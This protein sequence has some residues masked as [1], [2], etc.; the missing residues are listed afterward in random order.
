MG[1]INLDRGGLGRWD[2]IL[3]KEGREEF[4]GEFGVL[5]CVSIGTKT[6]LG[7]GK[8]EWEIWW[9]DGRIWDGGEKV[10]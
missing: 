6:A 1:D 8:V 5:D 9:V 2:N 7:K 10:G 4:G 3:G